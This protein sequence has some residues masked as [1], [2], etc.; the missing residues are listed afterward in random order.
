[1]MLN[2]TLYLPHTRTC[3]NFYTISANK[4]KALKVLNYYTYSYISLQTQINKSHI[5][6]GRFFSLEYRILTMVSCYGEI[7]LLVGSLS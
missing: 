3:Q 6:Y 7:K 1:M 5:Y 2:V 4:Q